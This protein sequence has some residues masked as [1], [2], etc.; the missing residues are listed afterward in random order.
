MKSG[1]RTRSYSLHVPP[2]AP[3]REPLA[4]VLSFHG[5]AGT[6]AR[7]EETVRLRPKADEKGFLLVTPEGTG[8]RPG[9]L[10]TWNA[11][12][13]CGYARDRNVDDVGFV[14]DLID[15]VQAQACVDPKR[16]YATGFSNGSML[17][18]RLGCELADRIAAIAPVGGGIGDMDMDA[19]PPGKLFECRPSRPV[20]VF[21]I[22]GNED[23]CYPFVGGAGNGLSGETKIGIRDSMSRWTAI[24]RCS[25][26][27]WISHE[28]GAAKCMSWAGC[29]AETTLCT[30]ADGGHAWPGTPARA[31]FGILF[32][33]GGLVSRD[34]KATDAIWNFFATHPMK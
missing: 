6:G 33:G 27:T 3:G 4:L 18:H 2:G 30:I 20:P 29:A 31:T 10:Q 21:A 23:G 1:G 14:R 19:T 12:N 7:H 8:P 15:A 22:H 13:C 9:T 28:S 34:L 25:P 24:N 17:S 32:C 11:G 26:K 16:V 5:G